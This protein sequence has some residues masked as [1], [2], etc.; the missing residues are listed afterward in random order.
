MKKV[1]YLPLLCMFFSAANAQDSS[2]QQKFVPRSYGK[3]SLSYLSNVVYNG[4]KDSVALPYMSVGLGYYHRSGFFVKGSAAYL[5]QA[6]N[7]RFDLFGLSG[8]YNWDAGRWEGTASGYLSFYNANSS[9]VQA[10]QSGGFAAYTGY[11]AG[12]I[13]AGVDAGISLGSVTDYSTSFSLE[14]SFDFL[15]DAFSI[16]PGVVATLGTQNYYAAYY[17][18]KH[19]SRR[20][21]KDS[22]VVYTAKA[23]VSAAEQF[24]WQCVEFSL[25]IDYYAG[26]FHAGFTANYAL[27]LNPATVYVQFTGSDGSQPPRKMIAEPISN[28][29]YFTASVSYRLKKNKAHQPAASQL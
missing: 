28:S 18:N 9:N 3:I 16:T 22:T 12:F 11:D 2:L 15:H 10:S 14:H 17:A 20:R 13:K 6:G 27:P 26:K 29:F 8:G 19:Y 25:P 1:F 4:R 21:K 23:D 5:A 24:R 7:G